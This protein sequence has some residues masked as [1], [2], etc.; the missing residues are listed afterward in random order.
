MKFGGVCIILV[1]QCII[2]IEGTIPQPLNPMV[3]FNRVKNKIFNNEKVKNSDNR[4]HGQLDSKI[5]DAL[6]TISAAVELP[7][8]A[9]K[10][11]LSNVTTGLD[12]DRSFSNFDSF[13]DRFALIYPGTK[14]C[15]NG[16]RSRSIDDLGYHQ[17]TD[18]CCRDHDNC[19]VGIPGRESQYGLHNTGLFTRS[20]CDCDK[21]FYNCLKSSN[22]VTSNMIAFTYFSLLGPQCFDLKP[23]ILSCLEFRINRCV[24]YQFDY[25]SEPRYQWFD[26]PI[27]HVHLLN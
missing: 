5:R 4:E 2:S 18:M 25:N 12:T 14:W 13:R 16:D 20:R 24:K 21:N 15:G 19:P 1:L 27:Y 11:T 7:I 9:I 8:S 10:F 17:D 3:V 6:R 22:S 26:N 23:R